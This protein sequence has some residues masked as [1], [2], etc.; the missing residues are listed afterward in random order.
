MFN[1]TVF[2]SFGLQ[3]LQEASNLLGVK[4]IENEIFIPIYGDVDLTI[5]RISMYRLCQFFL[6]PNINSQC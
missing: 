6:K 3:V 2:C 4:I 1:L 5:Q